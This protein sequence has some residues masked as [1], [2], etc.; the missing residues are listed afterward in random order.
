M[1]RT[2]D[3]APLVSIC[4]IAYNHERYIG[5][6]IEGFLAQQTDFGVEIIIHDDRSTDATA[7]IA[8][9]PQAR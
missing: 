8:S 2:E 5:Q 4:C 9:P 6:A 3:A 1:T 7:A